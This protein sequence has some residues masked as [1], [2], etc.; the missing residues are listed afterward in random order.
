MSS[1]H[2]TIVITGTNTG[3]GKSIVTAGLIQQLHLNKVRA[4]GIK[5]VE[6]GCEYGEDHNLI[7]ADG[8]LLHSM[9]PWVPANTVA[10][11]RFRL[12]IAA[13]LAARKSGIHLDLKDLTDVVV[14]ARHYAKLLLIEGAGGALSPLT[15]K[16][17]MLDLAKTLDAPIIICAEDCLGTQSLTLSVIE[18]ARN[19]GLKILGVVLSC[20]DPNDAVSE[21]KN[22]ETIAQWGQVEVFGSLS[23]FDGDLQEI[24]KEAG[25]QLNNFGLVRR[26]IDLTA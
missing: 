16:H 20:L 12:P 23:K 14:Q 8:A 5:P 18:N 1:K 6:T 15:E 11:Y 19:R 2:E 17:N 7:A 3:V 22:A 26:V 9:A 21:Q 4:A 13:T 10:P 24:A 25:V